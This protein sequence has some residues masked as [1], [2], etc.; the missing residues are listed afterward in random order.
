MAGQKTLSAR[1]SLTATLLLAAST[2]VN[3]QAANSKPKP[4]GSISGR[5][6]IDGK[7]APWIPVAA[8]EGQNVN[9]RDAPARALSDIEGNYRIVGLRAGEYQ[10]W[11]LT[12]ALV[13][14]ATA[15]YFSYSGA[16]KS[17]LL[18]ADENLTDVDLKLIRGAVI[19]GRVTNADNKPVVE[20][21]IK[22]QL[23]DAN[24]NPRLGAIGNPYDQLF[25]TDDR[26]IYRI[27]DLSPGRYRV[28]VGFDAAATDGLGMV[29]AHRY[30]QTF[31]LDPTDQTKPGIVELSEGDEAKNIDIR[32]GAVATTFSVSGRVIDTETG[33]PIAKAGVS[34]SMASKDPK[35]QVPGFIIQ[36]DDRGEF[37]FDGFAAGHYSVTPSAEYYGGNFYGDPVSFEITDKDVTGLELRTVPGLSLSGYLSADGLSTKELMAQLPNLMIVA[38]GSTPGN[39]QIRSG[40]RAMIAPDGTFEIDGLRPGR[41]VSL[42]V[43]TQR[44]SPVR[45][46]I[47]RVERDGVPVNQNF[48]LKESMSGLHVVIDYGTGS[49]RGTVKFE[50]GDTPITDSRM[51]VTCKREGS[52]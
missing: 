5:I 44:P 49:I 12:P 19:T 45:T 36:T 38:T 3:A 14:E 51:N 32:V 42:W 46:I 29:R 11:T 17:V 50:G 18:G 20:E 31:Y 39:D 33:T 25:Q 40:G 27:F 34:F 9:R 2:L 43:S 48:E 10:V 1:I 22:L 7:A 24:G 35:Q 16:A 52:R 41:P 6:T 30:D 37:K 26:G 13:A 23:L 8:V 4:T 21:R 28:S 47:N 15:N